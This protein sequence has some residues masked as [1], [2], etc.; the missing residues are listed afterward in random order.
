MINGKVW[1]AISPRNPCNVTWDVSKCLTRILDPLYNLIYGT[2]NFEGRGTAMITM[3]NGIS[4]LVSRLL[5]IDDMLTFF[6][7]TLYL[8]MRSHRSSCILLFSSSLLQISPFYFKT[9][10]CF[11]CC[12]LEPQI[13]WTLCLF[14]YSGCFLIANHMRA[15]SQT[16]K[17]HITIRR[18][19]IRRQLLMNCSV[20]LWHNL[21]TNN[22][23]E[24]SSMLLAGDASD[25]YIS[26]ELIHYFF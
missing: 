11:A 6:A 19:H 15:S 1:H 25:F 5:T 12:G 21:K 14:F 4:M 7:N 18:S 26:S 3:L 13:F 10:H 23:K 16:Q 20:H 9:L 2:L 8:S 22:W 24:N 17:R